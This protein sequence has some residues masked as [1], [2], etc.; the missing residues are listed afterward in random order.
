MR[1]KATVDRLCADGRAELLIR[2][3]SACSGDCHKC[4]GCG[5]VEQVLRIRAKNPVAAQKGD[6]V[7]VES[8]SGVVLKAAVLIYL[9]P[10]LLFLA[11]YLTAAFAASRAFLWG[12]GG[13]ALGLIPAFCYNR[14]V[15]QQPPEYTVV[16]FVE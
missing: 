7:Y 10:L 13:F 4:G 11:A 12:C 16:G 5:G 6:I 1:T 9:L 2:R 14:R 15:K 8:E 3:E